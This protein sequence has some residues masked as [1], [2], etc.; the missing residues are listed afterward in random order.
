LALKTGKVLNPPESCPLRTNVL[1]RKALVM[2]RRESM[3]V[4][5][6]IWLLKVIGISSQYKNVGS[7]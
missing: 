2:Y 6:C 7:Y 5:G 4:L 3:T 1:C